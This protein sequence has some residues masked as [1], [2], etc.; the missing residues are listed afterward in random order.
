MVF[1]TIRV[2]HALQ[3]NGPQ[4][5]A[6]QQQLGQIEWA[7]ASLAHHLGDME[8]FFTRYSADFLLTW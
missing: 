4:T 5:S 6:G 3:L 2:Y 7:G 8:V 1:R